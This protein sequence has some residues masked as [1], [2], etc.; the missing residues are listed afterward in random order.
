[1]GDKKK[2]DE[3]KKAAQKILDA[4][5]KDPQAKDNPGFE[6]LRSYVKTLGT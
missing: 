5:E 3:H 4:L 6:N 2:A 1:L